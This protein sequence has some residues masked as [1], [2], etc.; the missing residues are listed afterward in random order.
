MNSRPWGL[1]LGSLFSFIVFAFSQI[2]ALLVLFFGGKLSPYLNRYFGFS[3]TISAF[4]SSILSLILIYIFILLSKYPL[5]EYLSLNDFS[6][7]SFFL[8]LFIFA[9]FI[10]FSEYI[11]YKLNISTIPDFLEK[12][13]KTTEFPLLLFF[14]IIF[15]YPIFEEVLFRG[16]LFKSIEN[17]NLGGIWAVI[18]TSFF[19]SILHI[20]YN[21]IIIIVIFIAGL[22]FGFSRLKTSSLFV[23][24]VLHILQNFVSSIFFYLSL[25]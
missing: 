19:W 21:L 10:G 14:V 9:S 12:A 18:I 15:V 13:Y 6:F 24:L 3:L 7:K 11:L 20:Q 8:W 17:S 5:K 22:I 23:P 2:S 25:K 16:F 4:V 1:G